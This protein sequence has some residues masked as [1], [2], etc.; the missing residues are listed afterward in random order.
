MIENFKILL[1]EDDDVAAEA[2]Q[3]SFAKAGLNISIVVAENGQVA[4]DIIHNKHESLIVEKPFVV[5][6]DLNMPVMNG[7]EFLDIIRKDKELCDIV[8]FILTTS[9]DDSD[10]SRAYHNNVAGYMV[11]SAVGPQFSK[12]SKLLEAYQAAIEL[13][14]S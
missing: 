3:R 9:N 12:L 13:S 4:L 14:S 11:K 8:V 2:V 5:L 6:L 1:V 10:R 7:F